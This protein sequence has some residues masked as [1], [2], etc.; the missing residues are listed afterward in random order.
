MFTFGAAKEVVEME[1]A[2]TLGGVW[3]HDGL[4]LTL[5]AGNHHVPRVELVFFWKLIR[6][7]AQRPT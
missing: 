7:C 4:L 1:F 3:K 5:L 2:L 6:C